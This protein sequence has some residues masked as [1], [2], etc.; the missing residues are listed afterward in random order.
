MTAMTARCITVLALA[1]FAS[2]ALLLLCVL[3][4]DAGIR[5]L[6]AA[7]RFA[8]SRGVL[9]CL[10]LLPLCATL[11]VRAVAKPPTNGVNGVCKEPCSKGIYQQ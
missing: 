5:P 8:R 7:G 4:R 9:G 2:S 3:C 1:G 10:V 11:F 6:R